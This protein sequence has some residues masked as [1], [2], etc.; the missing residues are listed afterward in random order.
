MTDNEIILESLK[1]QLKEAIPEKIGSPI[2]VKRVKRIREAIKAMTYTVSEIKEL[3]D[4]HKITDEEFWKEIGIDKDL[5]YCTY[6]TYIREDVQGAI[7]R[8]I[9]ERSNGKL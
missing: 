7:D 5:N 8:V 1:D 9:K 6:L 3:L 2:D 4:Y